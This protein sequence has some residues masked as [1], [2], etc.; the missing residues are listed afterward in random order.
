M[1][2]N[3][4]DYLNV[5]ECTDS[6]PYSNLVRRSKESSPPD[7]RDSGDPKI[8]TKQYCVYILSSKPYGTLYIGITSNLVKRV[9]EHKNKFVEGFTKKYCV[10]K[11]VYYEICSDP[12]TAIKRE[13]RLKRYPR[14]WKINL[15]EKENPEWLDLYEKI[16]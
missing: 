10:D 15:I 4:K 5:C 13:K 1:E 14:Q 11:L 8:M 12:E 3:L 6:L 9:W 16:L 7:F 2:G